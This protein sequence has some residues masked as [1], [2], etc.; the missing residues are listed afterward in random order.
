[1]GRVWY[2]ELGTLW[3]GITL[4]VSNDHGPFLGCVVSY[5]VYR[6]Q[7]G[8]FVEIDLAVLR[9][10]KDYAV[11]LF[12]STHRSPSPL[13]HAPFPM[14]RAPHPQLHVC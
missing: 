9:K 3:N 6:L 4:S 2:R 14:L 8:F 1:M 7:R 5:D 11:A 12:S 10:L 13:P